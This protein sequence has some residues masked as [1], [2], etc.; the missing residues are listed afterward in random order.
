M[1]DLCKFGGQ[2]LYRTNGSNITDFYGKF[3]YILDGD[4]I[5]NWSSRMI[6]YKFDGDRIKDFYGKILYSFDGEYFK[7]FYGRILYTYRNGNISKFA[8]VIEYQVKGPATRR[9]VATFILLFI[10]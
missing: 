3:L 4:Y 2:I 6:E 1:A 5:R 10:V 9:E 8:S 7:D